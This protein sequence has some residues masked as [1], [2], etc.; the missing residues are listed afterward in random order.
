M[1]KTIKESM[2]HISL[3]QQ[4][5]NSITQE[6]NNNN[7]I[8]YANSKDKD[9]T[10]FDFE[11]VNQEIEALNAEILKIRS[12]INKANQTTMVGVN[13]YSI[14]DALIRIAQLSANSERFKILASNK[15]KD[16]NSTFSGSIEYT[17]YLYDVKVAKEL[18]LTT[19]EKIHQLQTA[20]DKANILT[21]IE[22]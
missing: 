22:I 3:L 19:V 12:A 21:E 17:E 6:E 14:S 9:E 15:Q 10:D 5:I 13:D 2:K 7:F 18:Y 8:N 4:Q 1:K 20:V 11:A 16:R